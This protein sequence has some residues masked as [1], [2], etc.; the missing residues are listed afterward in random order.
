MKRCTTHRNDHECLFITMNS[1]KKCFKHTTEK[2]RID[3]EA[4]AK[5]VD[6]KHSKNADARFLSYA[7]PVQPVWCKESSG[8]RPQPLDVNDDFLQLCFIF[9]LEAPDIDWES[10]ALEI[11]MHHARN[12]RQKFG[13]VMYALRREALY[14]ESHPEEQS[15]SLDDLSTGLQLSHGGPPI[16]PGDGA[17]LKTFHPAVGRCLPSQGGREIE[18]PLAAGRS[19]GLTDSLFREICIRHMS[20][21]PLIDYDVMLAKYNYTTNASA[22]GRF[23][24]SAKRCGPDW[25]FP[26]STNPKTSNSITQP[27]SN[28]SRE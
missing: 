27:L 28:L 22:I 15:T 26:A 7:R 5:V 11:G 10:L 13:A 4:V 6:I 20:K 21:R 19:N 23:M 2:P 1:F 18:L 12:A 3:F 8:E 25:A 9:M 16:L 24:K 14:G 17:A